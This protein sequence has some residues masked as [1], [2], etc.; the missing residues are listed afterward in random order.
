[1][2]ESLY[3]FV[4]KLNIRVRLINFLRQVINQVRRIYSIYCAYKKMYLSNPS[5]YRVCIITVYSHVTVA[6]SNT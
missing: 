5:L 3:K 2:N 6:I 1:M 4:Y